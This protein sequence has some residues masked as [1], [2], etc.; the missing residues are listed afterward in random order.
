MKHLEIYESLAEVQYDITNKILIK[1][2]IALYDDK[3][4]MEFGDV[5]YNNIDYT[6]TELTFEIL[7]NGTITWICTNS[8]IA[9][10][11]QYSK[12]N[13]EWTNITSTTSGVNINVLSGDKI[14]FRGNNSTYG[15][16]SYHNS[17]RANCNFN[18][19]GNIMSL[20]NGTNFMDLKV[21]S[22]SYTFTYLF[23]YCEKLLNINNLLLPATTLSDNCYERMFDTCRK[24][25][26]IPNLPATTLT[27]S[28]YS[29]MFVACDEL[30]DLS[31]HEF[32]AD[33]VPYA[34]YSA[35]FHTC[36]KLVKSPII[37]CTSIAS[38]GASFM[39]FNCNNLSWIKCLSISL[40][41]CQRWTEGVASTGTFIK[42]PSLISYSRDGYGIPSGWTIENA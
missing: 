8:S 36:P 16:S 31:H 38:Y 6:S 42:S 33:Y 24:I 30:T 22:A 1:P 9:K 27:S 19:Y 4:K 7:E 34:A 12:N 2:Y 25:I 35:M 10:T 23:A 39:F 32:N 41:G 40:G 29:C 15:N 3:H 14:K 37:K 18:A 11:I 21:L 17:F 28:C 26:D 20:I 13:G 5:V